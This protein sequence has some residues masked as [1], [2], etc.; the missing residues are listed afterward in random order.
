MLLIVLAV[1]YRCVDSAANT[2]QIQVHLNILNNSA[3]TIDMADLRIRYY[4]NKESATPEVMNIDYAMFGSSNVL[5]TFAE[6]Y[7]ELSFTTGAGT[8]ISGNSSGEIQ[9][10]FHKTDW[11]PYDQSNDYSFIPTGMR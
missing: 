5:Y 7:V 4:Y 10:R 3:E 8:I 6:N 2:Q 9:I 1:E 11:S